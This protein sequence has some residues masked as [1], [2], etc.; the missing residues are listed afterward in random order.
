MCERV[1]K[2]KKN[3]LI[4]TNKH[5]S[6]LSHGDREDIEMEKSRNWH[7]MWS[8]FYFNKKH[9]GYLNAF[10]KTFPNLITSIIKT[11]IYLIIFNKSKRDIYFMRLKGLL[12]SYFLSKSF[13]R[14]YE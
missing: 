2:Y 7:W 3:F 10:I 14:P 8:K 5:L 4:N 12:N 9:Y 6:G 11:L 1:H 13:Y